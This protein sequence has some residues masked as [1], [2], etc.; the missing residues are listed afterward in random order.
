MIESATTAHAKPVFPRSYNEIPKELY[1]RA[2]LYPLELERI[3]HGAEW[4][5]IAHES[6][7]PNKGDF[8]TLR[9]AHIQL[10]LVRGADDRV[11][12]FYNSCTHRA[13]QVEAATSG[14][15]TE[16]ECPYHRWLFA[17]DGRLLGCPSQREYSPGFDRKNYG[18]KGPRHESFLGLIFVTFSAATEPLEEFLGGVQPTLAKALGGDGRLKPIGCQK[19]RYK[20][21][22]KVVTDNDNFHGPLLH[23]A[24]NMLNW[25]GNAG[26]MRAYTRRG[27]IALESAVVPPRGEKLLKD[28]S[29]VN[30]HEGSIA[31]SAALNLY[32][33][34]TATKHMDVFNL[35]FAT[36][37]G[38]DLIEINYAY[39]AHQDDDA[40][41][42]RH[43][44]RQG[45]NL[46]GPSGFISAEDAAVFQRT[47]LGNFSPGSAIFQKG[48]RD[49][50]RL[51]EDFNFNDESPA[52]IHWEHY[53]Q[54]MGFDRSTV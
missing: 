14:N 21:N 18:L 52:L 41:M 38:P 24:L 5:P 19:V 23:K 4:H 51:N 31:A 43:R 34:F 7:I 2:D 12:V 33:L 9:Y 44:I 49:P 1:T 26:V 30:V 11:R 39:F 48:V 35:R 16:F 46:L 53:R 20:T 42:L 25:Q 37:L 29:V 36:P 17:S 27:H 32:P 8:K 40:G 50:L 47:H 28:P 45:S 10:L 6:E 15:K 13:N 3:F 22:W 54:V